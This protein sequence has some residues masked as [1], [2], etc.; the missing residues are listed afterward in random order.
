M[1]NFA[2]TELSLS[3]TTMNFVDWK[4]KNEEEEE[5]KNTSQQN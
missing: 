2:E 1:H 3:V 4:E 5:E